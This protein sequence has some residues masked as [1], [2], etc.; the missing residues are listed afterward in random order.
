[1]SFFQGFNFDTVLAIISCLTGIIALFVGGTAYKKCKINNNSIKYKKTFGADCQDHSIT[2]GGDYCEG[3]NDKSLAI[4][5][6]QLSNHK[7]AKKS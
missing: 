4:I 5:M 2:V 7:K 3:I 1:M 6:K